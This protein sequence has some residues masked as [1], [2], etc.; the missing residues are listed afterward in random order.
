ML[1]MIIA[2]DEFIVR[3]GLSTIIPWQEY[4]IQVIAEAADGQEAYDLCRELKP[5]I[6]FTDIRMPLM[7]GLEVA[8]KLK[9]EESNIRIIIISGVQDFNYAK[10]ALQVN[11]QGYIL[12]PVKLDELKEVVEKVARGIIMDQ[13]KTIELQQLKR[14]LHENLPVVREKFL[15]NLITGYYQKEQLIWDKLQYFQVPLEPGESIMAAVLQIDDY[16]RITE[17]RSEEDKQL[18][19]FSVSNITEEIVNNHAVGISSSIHENEFVLL[20]NQKSQLPE[21]CMEICDEIASSI[22]KYLKISVS[23]GLGRPVSSILQIPLSYDDAVTALQ[24]RFYTGSSSI[25]NIGDVKQSSENL[26]SI[27]LYD[28]ENKLMSCMKSGDDGGILL[29]IDDIFKSFSPDVKLPVDYVQSICIE[30]VCMAS[31]TLCELQ[32]SIDSIVCSRSQILDT[33]YRTETFLGLKEYMLS[34]FTEIAG[35][36]SRKF[37]QKNNK[38]VSRIKELIHQQYMLNIGVGDISKEVFLSPNYISLIFKQETGTTI[39]EYITQVRMEAAKKLLR[40]TEMKVLEVAETV[41]YENPQY[42]STVFKKYSGI[43]PQQFRAAATG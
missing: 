27:H 25:L 18:L 38:V 39:V 13:N 28:A 4:G 5:D 41:G 21:R 15:R 11:A 29:S 23:I 17:S 20:F 12:K 36:F 24:Y 35:Y 42:F 8:M 37:T 40:E 14:Q 19:S 43:H 26:D 3:D 33:I 16:N 2:D 1:K 30:L 10:T 22:A 7:D 34:L 6:L 31:R 9:E 32:E